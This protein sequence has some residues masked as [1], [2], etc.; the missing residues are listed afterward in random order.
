M[1]FRHLTN[2]FPFLYTWVGNI[3]S[4]SL[5]GEMLS[6]GDR[7]EVEIRGCSIWCVE[8][9]QAHLCKLVEQRDNCSCSV[10]SAIID[11][12]LWAYAKRHHKDMAHVPIHHTRCIYY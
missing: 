8:R 3:F 10:N 12:Y 6:S 11:F 9:I 2:T 4:F 7:R 5:L 1:A